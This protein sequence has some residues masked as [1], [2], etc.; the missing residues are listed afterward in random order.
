MSWRDALG[1]T[2]RTDNGVIPEQT[3]TDDRDE[4]SATPGWDQPGA[5]ETVLTPEAELGQRPIPP[6]DIP[7]LLV[8]TTDVVET[9]ERA[10]NDFSP[11]TLT[12]R[13]DPF[14]VI[15][16]NE[17]AKS[18][19]L[20]NA[21]SATVFIAKA[22]DASQAAAFPLLPGASLSLPVRSDVYAFTAAGLTSS[23][24]IITT[25]VDG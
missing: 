1:L 13:P 10:A 9:D 3:R 8:K 4:L 14:R 18:R 16:R 24:A 11:R 6:A 23:L 15:N 22:A 7:P 25:L 21:G 2:E 12:V 19:L 20:L 5:G 17:T